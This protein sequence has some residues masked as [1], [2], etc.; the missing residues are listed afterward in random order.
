M[1]VINQRQPDDPADESFHFHAAPPKRGTAFKGSAKLDLKVGPRVLKRAILS[2]F[3][4]RDDD[5]I[6]NESLM[7]AK[8]K[9]R[10]LRDEFDFNRPEECIKLEGEEIT[11]L[12]ALLNREF[13]ETGRYSLARA[14]ADSAISE[15]VSALVNDGKTD[16]EAV[17][18]LVQALADIP[19]VAEVLDG[20]SGAG[21]LSDAIALRKQRQGLAA[22]RRAAED[23][24]SS[25]QDFQD[26]LQSNPWIFGGKFMGEAAR[27]SLVV[28]E[29]L[30]F[31]L[32]RPDGSLHIVEIK[33]AEVKSLVRVYRNKLI[34]G[35]DVHDAVGQAMNYLKSLDIEAD[36][37]L[38]HFGIDSARASATVVVGHP[39]YLSM[40]DYTETDVACALRA[41]NSHLS[42]VEVITYK[43]LIDSAE[44]SLSLPSV[45]EGLPDQRLPAE[46]SWDGARG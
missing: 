39:A 34:A 25:E 43:D 41:Y 24:T 10:T 2:G 45:A 8:Y 18:R 42:R 14:D 7:M 16:V 1:L 37:I 22:L 3:G 17:H 4:P 26:V 12:Q 32:L 9:R 11:R 15:A 46:D 28:G 36:R 31:P 30:D 21:L 33:K 6:G 5:K 29:Q 23:P 13:P 20:A 44:R 40:D 38:R 35:H 19:G 27:R